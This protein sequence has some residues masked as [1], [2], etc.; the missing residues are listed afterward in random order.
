MFIADLF[1]ISKNWKQF[2]YPPTEEW[3]NNYSTSTEWNTP[4]KL[5]IHAIT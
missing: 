2:K 3:L 4:Q 1:I 5:W